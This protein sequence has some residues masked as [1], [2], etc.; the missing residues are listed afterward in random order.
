M[1]VNEIEKL[2]MFDGQYETTDSDEKIVRREL[3][4]VWS[5]LL[6][7]YAQ[8]GIP[9]PPAESLRKELIDIGTDAGVEALVNEHWYLF[10]FLV[11]GEVQ[12][13]IER[14]LESF[15]LADFL[16]DVKQT[17]QNPELLGR[18]LEKIRKYVLEE[19]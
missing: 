9:I 1:Y 14:G 18:M 10:D 6:E 17:Q 7:K 3:V 11:R 2:N 5:T 12:E 4:R 8:P 19:F 13:K 16:E 15:D